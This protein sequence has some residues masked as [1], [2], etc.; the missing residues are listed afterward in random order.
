MGDAV[1]RITSSFTAP[2]TSPS[3]PDHT[4]ASALSRSFVLSA[5]MAHAVHPNYAAKHEKGHGPQL[6]TGMVR[7]RPCLQSRSMARSLPA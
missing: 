5:D 4:L 7:Y 2:P 6:N 1:R 3:P